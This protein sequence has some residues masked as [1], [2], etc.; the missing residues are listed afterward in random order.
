MGIAASGYGGQFDGCGKFS[1]SLK[2]LMMILAIFSKIT[3]TNIFSKKGRDALCFF[4]TID[5]HLVRLLLCSGRVWPW[6]SS[7]S[8]WIK[9]TI[10]YQL[11]WPSS[12]LSIPLW[13]WSK[14]S[15][16]D[17]K[18]LLN[19]LF[20]FFSLKPF[21]TSAIWSLQCIFLII[22]IYRH[23][24]HN[25]HYLDFH[26]QKDS[27][28]FLLLWP[29]KDISQGECYNLKHWISTLNYKVP[30]VAVNCSH[31]LHKL[32]VLGGFL[33]LHQPYSH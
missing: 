29:A 19:L 31:H 18:N 21:W 23:H 13:S 2:M 14:M 24:Q 28:T 16:P 12:S 30:Q 8:S 27:S 6:S 26:L 11:F 33:I 25:H 10:L 9:S 4:F 17:P 32:R 7:S 15:I 20:T 1:I 5:G 22:T 3:T